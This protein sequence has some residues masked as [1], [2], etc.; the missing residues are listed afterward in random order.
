[1]QCC[2]ERR[3]NETDKGERRKKRRKQGEG[4]GRGDTG[5]QEEKIGR[6]GKEKQR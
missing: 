6:R 1:M 2:G 3:E 4:K 5:K